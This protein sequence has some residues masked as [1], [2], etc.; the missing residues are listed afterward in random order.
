M[1]IINGEEKLV[2]LLYVTLTLP[3]TPFFVVIKTTPLEASEPYN[4]AAEGPV[5]I[6]MLSISSGL[7]SATLLVP[8][9]LFIVPPALSPELTLNIGIP[10]IT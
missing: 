9:C 4:A 2:L 1:G 6:V 8:G 10:S 3:A 7:I 5:K